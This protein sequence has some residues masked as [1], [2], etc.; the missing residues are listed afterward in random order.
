[1]LNNVIEDHN[2]KRKVSLNSKSS[3]EIEM[4]KKLSV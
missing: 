3:N 1:M 2:L 4:S